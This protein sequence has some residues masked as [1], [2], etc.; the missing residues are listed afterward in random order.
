MNII[1]VLILNDNGNFS[2]E[3]AGRDL[4]VL[5]FTHHNEFFSSL[6]LLMIATSTVRNVECNTRELCLSKIYN[7][8]RH[9]AT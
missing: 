9:G 3:Y 7:Y 2:S 5:H 1:I 6:M 4:S 8:G